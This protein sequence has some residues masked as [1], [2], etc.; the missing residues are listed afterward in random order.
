MPL[1]TP[2]GAQDQKAFIAACMKSKVVQNDFKTQEQRLAVCYSQ[3]KKH[4]KKHGKANWEDAEIEIEDTGA[5]SMEGGVHLVNL[6]SLDAEAADA[7]PYGDVTYADPGYQADKKKRYPIDTEEH[8][9]AAW[10]YIN[11]SKNGGEYTSEQRSKIKA[12]IVSAWKRKIDPKG[13]PSA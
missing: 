5:L 1:P 13:P 10:S 8:I 11:K 2:S 9:R 4:L 7:K 12:R 6:P 3:W